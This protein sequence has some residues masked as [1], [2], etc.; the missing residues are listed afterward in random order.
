M[1]NLKNKSNKQNKK[2][3]IVT[4]NFDGCQMGEELDSGRKEGRD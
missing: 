4:E 1:W 2:K 3:L